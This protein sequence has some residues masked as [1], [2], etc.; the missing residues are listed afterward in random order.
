MTRLEFA[1]I[2]TYFLII[3]LLAGVVLLG[4]V[5]LLQGWLS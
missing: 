4:M 2:A 5:A 1:L 3:T